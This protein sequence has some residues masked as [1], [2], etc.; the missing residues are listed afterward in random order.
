MKTADWLFWQSSL[1]H[2]HLPPGC[3]Q[4]VV[5]PSLPRR[6]L[7]C[8]PSSVCPFQ[9]KHRLDSKLGSLPTYRREEVASPRYGPC[10]TG[11]DALACPLLG[12]LRAFSF[13]WYAKWTHVTECTRLRRVLLPTWAA[14]RART[15]Y[16][17][18]D[19]N[20]GSCGHKSLLQF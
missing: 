9:N 7:T 11:M 1:P 13:L 16:L 20:K 5:S 14:Q 4:E 12:S 18:S 19:T 2:P 6:G 15:S 17:D 10:G 3:F 8:Y